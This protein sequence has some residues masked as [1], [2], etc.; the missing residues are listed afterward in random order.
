QTGTNCKG[1]YQKARRSLAGATGP[2]K[3]H[4][5]HCGTCEHHTNQRSTQ[6]LAVFLR[7]L[8]V[9]RR[10]RSRRKTISIPTAHRL[11]RY[12]NGSLHLQLHRDT[13]QVY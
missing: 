5:R 8:H 9:R 1:L 3:E 4:E 12:R 13:S 10:G 2:E 7:L 11:F 6:I